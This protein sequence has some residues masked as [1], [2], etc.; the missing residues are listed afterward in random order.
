MPIFGRDDVVK[1]VDVQYDEVLIPEWAPQGDPEPES[2]IMRLRG[3][4]GTERDRWEASM[5]PRG[6]S[7]KPNLENFRARLIIQ[8]AVD[9][10]GNRI[11]NAGDAKMI[12]SKSAKAISRVFDKCQEMNGLSESD[13][14]DLTE[15]FGDDPN[16]DSTSG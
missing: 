16:G 8:C 14:E 12:G 11:F 1:A 2:W 6:N 7:K 10:D 13:V 15:D 9:Q 3:M 5:Q 4:T